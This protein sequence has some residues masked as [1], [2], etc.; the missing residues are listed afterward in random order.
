MFVE[1]KREGRVK[2]QQESSKVFC[3]CTGMH[4]EQIAHSVSWIPR[5]IVNGKYDDNNT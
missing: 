2:R 5:K 1:T 4:S 3:A